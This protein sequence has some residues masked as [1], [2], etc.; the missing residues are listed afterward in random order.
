MVKSLYKI[1]TTTD[2]H[3]LSSK[4][5]YNH[6]VFITSSF[7]HEVNNYSMIYTY[8]LLSSLGCTQNLMLK[9]NDNLLWYLFPV[10]QS[11]SSSQ[12]SSQ[13]HNHKYLCWCF[14]Y[15]VYM[16]LVSCACACLC[17]TCAST[18]V[19]LLNMYSTSKLYFHNICKK[20]VPEAS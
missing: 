19:C 10:S 8:I 13:Y 14:V 6:T 1:C 12:S 5:Y 2:H 15:V 11:Q 7:I 20:S 3:Q 16:C 4:F 18:S 17:S 9:I